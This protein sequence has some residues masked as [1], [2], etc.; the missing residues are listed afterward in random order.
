MPRETRALVTAGSNCQASQRPRKGVRSQGP[1]S[2]KSSWRSLEAATTSH[3]NK[4]EVTL[5]SGFAIARQT[6]RLPFGADRAREGCRSVWRIRLRQVGASQ[7]RLDPKFP[8][9][10]Q[11]WL[12]TRQLSVALSELDRRD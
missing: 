1:P 2:Y 12:G 7:E 11:V 6:D 9:Y 5:P 8:E 10:R 4:I 3:K